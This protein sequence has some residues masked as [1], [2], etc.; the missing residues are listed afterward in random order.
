MLAV[1][2]VSISNFLKNLIIV[3]KL[4]TRTVGHE[5]RNQKYKYLSPSKVDIRSYNITININY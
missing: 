2:C 5:V 1:G 3:T 4:R